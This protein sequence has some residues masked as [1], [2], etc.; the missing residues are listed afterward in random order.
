[1]K[2]I[3]VILFAVMLVS[4]TLI[5][6]VNAGCDAFRE[7]WVDSEYPTIIDNPSTAKAASYVD[8]FGIA[9]TSAGDVVRFDE[10]D[11]GA[12]GAKS[13]VVGFAYG[14]KSEVT[15][16]L[17]VDSM[18]NTPAAVYKIGNTGGWDADHTKD[19]VQPATIS[20]GTHTIFLKWVDGTGS[21]HYIRFSN[22]NQDV[23]EEDLQEEIKPQAETESPNTGDTG[24]VASLITAAISGAALLIIKKMK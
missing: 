3:S 24:L 6:T 8:G 17:Y 20:K 21:L 23:K 16:E 22:G 11:F 19:F 2:K 4:Y 18:E 14:E 9:N 13:A 12:S 5:F 1:M 7:T 10:V 15:I